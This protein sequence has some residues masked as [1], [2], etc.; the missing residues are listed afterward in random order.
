V[1]ILTASPAQS[2]LVSHIL[3]DLEA[4]P[5]RIY[6][7]EAQDFRHWPK[8]PLVILEPA[9]EAPHLSHPWAWPAFGRQRVSLAWTL[10]E[11]RIW[12]AGR[13]DWLRP[14]PAGAP[15][16]ALW[17]LAAKSAPEANPH[18]PRKGV[19]PPSFWEALDKA[20]KEVWA[21]VPTF[22]P[23]WWRPLEEHFLA[24]A[25]RRVQITILSA[26][27]GPGQ[28]REY[29]SAA[30]RTLATY[31]CAIHLAKGFPGFMAVVDGV[32][33]TWGHFVEGSQGAHIW[34]GLKSAE[35][36]LAAPF[37]SE[38]AQIQTI[39]EK[40]GRK[41]GGLKNCRV[42]GWP[43]VL[44]NEEIMRG[45]GDEQPLKVGCLGE[46]GGKFQHRRLDE[47]EPFLAPPKCG[48]DNSTPYQRKGRGRAAVWVC[49]HHPDGPRCPSYKV[50]PG[51]AL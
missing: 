26:P 22:E 38:I 29:P 17:Q 41:S 12:L 11:E 46:H 32:H 8:V 3:K 39:N 49:P 23:F 35:L 33:F 42:C 14:L 37:L 4:P 2:Q 31:G 9:F 36:P 28:D 48:V 18:E 50:V 44:I 25:R 16:A 40:L 1:I 5:G 10:A 20:K 7:G 24:A 21:I 34:G 47:R 19:R 6:C 30:I 45:Y 51:D 43:M 27:P 15:L 13:D